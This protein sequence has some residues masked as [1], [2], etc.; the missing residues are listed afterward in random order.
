MNIIKGVTLSEQ[1]RY[2]H[3]QAYCKVLVTKSDERSLCKN[4]GKL[5]NLAV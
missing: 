4:V 3:M 2:K 1:L 5:P